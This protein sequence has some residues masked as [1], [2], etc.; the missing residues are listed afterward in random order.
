MARHRSTL[1]VG[2]CNVGAESRD[3]YTNLLE[4]LAKAINQ[5][6]NFM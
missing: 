4:D 6:R 5:C 3:V 1:T 2:M